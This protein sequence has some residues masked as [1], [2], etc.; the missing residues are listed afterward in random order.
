MSPSEILQGYIEE[1]RT[2]LPSLTEGLASLG[3]N[4][5]QPDLIK[6]LHRLVHTIKGASMMVDIPGL[7]N[8]ALQMETALA[9]ILSKKL[10][11][12]SEA[13]QAM[14]FTVDQFREYC[15]DLLGPGVT[16]RQ[17]VRET[18]LTYRRL[19]GFPDAEDA[20]IEDLLK[21][22]P[23]I[24]GGG[25]G[26][27]ATDTEEEP[28]ADLKTDP[29]K[30]VPPAPPDATLTSESRPEFR[31]SDIPSE[32]LE[33]FYEEAKEHLEIGRA[34]CRERVCHRV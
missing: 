19:R 28:K 23:E 3:E 27:P 17:K 6:E 4:P 29:E 24:E 25:I 34:S 10:P 18:V 32:L 31:L 21:G 9:D 26:E 12:T 20:E 1:V 14:V 5:A 15:S 22:I 11:F 16:S 13:L 7:S 8:I 30:S 33:S 2:Y